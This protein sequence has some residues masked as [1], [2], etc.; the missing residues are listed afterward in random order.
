MADRMDGEHDA[1]VHGLSIWVGL[2]AFFSG[3]TS[4]KNQA[5]EALRQVR[6][7]FGGMFGAGGDQ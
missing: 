1:P 6:D 4:D 7:A 5:H 2:A 3:G